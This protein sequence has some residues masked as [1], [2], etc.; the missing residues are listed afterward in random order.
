MGRCRSL[1]VMVRE[2]GYSTDTVQRL[3]RENA[4]NTFQ[5]VGTLADFLEVDGQYESVVDEFLRDELNY[6]VVKSWDAAH[7]GMRLLKSE[8]DGRAT[9]LVHP[10]DAQAKFSFAVDSEQPAPT[11]SGKDVVRLRDKI[12]VLDGF[13]RSLEVILPKL[14]DGY[15]APDASTART[16]ALENPEAFFLSPSGE[17]FHNVTVSGGRQRA[18]GPLAIKRE[19]REAQMR[20]ESLASQISSLEAALGSLLSEITSVTHELDALHQSRRELELASANTGATLRERES[21]AARLTRR[22]QELS[23]AL[24][25]TRAAITDRENALTQLRANSELL[26]Q[27]HSSLEAQLIH[28]QS[29]VES[30][31]AA[32]ESAQHSAAE[33]RLRV[34]TLE[35]RLRGATAQHAR[36]ASLHD[37]AAHRLELGEQQLAQALAEKEHRIAENLQLAEQHTSLEAS[38][39]AA[40]AEAQQFTARATAL[41][42][43][44]AAAEQQLRQLRIESDSLR[45]RRAESLSNLARLKSELEHLEQACLNDLAVEAAA[46]RVDPNIPHLAGDELYASVAETKSMRERLEA[47]GPVNLEA[48]QEHAEVAERHAFLEA[49]RKDLLDSIENTEA[50]IKDIDEVSRVKFDEAFA[51]INENFAKTFSRLFGGGQAYM[52]LTD[53]ENSMES[54]VDIIASPPG[55]RLQNVLLLSGGEKALTALSLLMAIFQFQPSPFCVLDEVD[56]PLDETNNGRFCALM[57]ELSE[58][59]QFIII[60]HSKRTMQDAGL[61]FGVTMQEPGVS[62][63][64]SVNIAARQQQQQRA[65]A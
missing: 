61:I 38:R 11:G 23:P 32:R 25:R 30:L 15:V 43:Q 39:A 31:H 64:V 4:Q 51:A 47:M 24:E 14:R 12:H 48:L 3:L 8:V 5:T 49:Q 6:V 18:E 27:Q 57:R 26:D 33:A 65:S 41:R 45:D 21:E 36:I 2:H 55:K 9:F 1:D 28:L 59:T 44:A 29:Q 22:L 46:L 10:T 7:E 60:T 34:A 54:G 16:L 19:L 50:T 35:E 17:C 40:L 62:K 56:A 37:D 20:A 13:G 58:H 42:A 63:L 52:R 53:A